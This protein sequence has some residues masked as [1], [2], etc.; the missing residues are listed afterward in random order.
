MDKKSPHILKTLVSIVVHSHWRS[1]ADCIRDEAI[2]SNSRN[3]KKDVT[4]LKGILVLHPWMDLSL[5]SETTICVDKA[6][7][8]LDQILV[9]SHW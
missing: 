9:V 4:L 3:Y 8:R 5:P 2:A 6:Y 1:I 7:T